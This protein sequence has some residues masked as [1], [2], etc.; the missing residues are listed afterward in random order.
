MKKKKSR[1]GLWSLLLALV[2]VISV[3][4]GAA[5]GKYIK[6][7]SFTGTLKITAELGTITLQ[8]SK[9]V[10]MDD[11]RYTLV[12][13]ETVGNTYV[14]I[15]GLNIPKDPYITV[16][17]KSEIDAYLFVEVV[18]NT[19]GAIRWRIAEGWTLLDGVVGKHNGSVYVYTTPLDENYKS[20]PIQILN[21]DEIEVSQYL[22]TKDNTDEDVLQFYA[23]M[24]EVASG[25]TYKDVYDTIEQS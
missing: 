11:G 25:T 22:L 7:L 17:D 3:L 6:T 14:L 10:R 2:V 9:A 24:G 5:V 13:T 4:V 1:Y 23:A 15:P 18:D 21:K 16:T 12:E 19:N 8:E 20:T